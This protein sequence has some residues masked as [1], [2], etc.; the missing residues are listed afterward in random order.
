MP[1]T[2]INASRNNPLRGSKRTT[3]EGGI[4]VPIVISWPGHLNPGVFTQPAIQLD[5]TATALAAAGVKAGR[6]WRLE[7][8]NLLPFLTGEV[9]GSPHDA[10]YWR[11]GQQM[12]IRLGDYKLV[13]YDS[14]ADTLTG[15]RN[16][17]VTTAR[18]YNLAAD[19]GETQDLAAAMPDK[20]KELQSRWDAWNIA[21]VEPLWGG[22]RTD[23]GGAEPAAAAPKKAKKARTA[24]CGTQ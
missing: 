11:F 7:G 21:N 18:L 16:Q 13:R 12:A 2:T 22:G 20:V 10:L 17:P 23:S 6:D 5:L 14:N 24:L 4:R 1:G 3:L 9:T 19:I 8:I 15:A